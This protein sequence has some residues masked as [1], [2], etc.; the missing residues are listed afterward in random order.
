[1]PSILNAKHD[2]RARDA[3]KR[4]RKGPGKQKNVAGAQLQLHK[5]FMN[6]VLAITRGLGLMRAAQREGM[7]VLDTGKTKE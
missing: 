4:E 3:I 7:C 6:F 2:R 1:M 5:P